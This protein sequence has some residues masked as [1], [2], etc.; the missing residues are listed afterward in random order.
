MDMIRHDAPSDQSVALAI[1]VH[2]RTLNKIPDLRLTQ[3][4]GAQARV[5]N[6]VEAVLEFVGRYRR[7]QV[8]RHA[9]VQPEYN[10][11]NDIGTVEMRQISA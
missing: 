3:P 4:A 2:Q 7:S 6:G 10:R 9:V 8:R 1:K 11:L 5:E